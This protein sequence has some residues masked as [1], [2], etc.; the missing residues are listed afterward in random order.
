[1]TEWAELV[2][3]PIFRGRGLPPGDG[4]AVSVLPGLFGGDLYLRPLR[5]WLR[6]LGYRPMASGLTVNAGCLE[7]LSRRPWA[8]LEKEV[9]RG[10][11][12]LIGH[13]RGGVLA[14]ALA[15]RLQE[16]AS[17]LLLVGSPVGALLQMSAHD[18]ASAGAVPGRGHPV[19][20]AGQYARKVL[21]PKCSFPGCDCSF[22]RDLRRA[23]HP[24]TRVLSIFSR[25]DGIVHPHA[26]WVPG[27]RHIEV[28][29]SH[30]GLV[31][32]RA[33]YREL[34]ME[35]AQSDQV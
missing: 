6:R 10:P 22:E 8:G 2:A 4:R 34:A 14:R 7:R 28:S 19:A 33:V 16:R 1:M 21:D 18:F 30:S 20:E 32:N 26:S 5:G 23:L 27:A 3:D 31:Y 24:R 9:Q 15:A 17:H 13:S 11:I 25:E 35:L 29:G 12:A